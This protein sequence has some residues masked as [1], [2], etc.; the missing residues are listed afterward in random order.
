M[1]ELEFDLGQPGFKVCDP[2]HSGLLTLI[3]TYREIQYQNKAAETKIQT[4]R[5]KDRVMYMT[6]SCVHT[7]HKAACP[8][9]LSVL[10]GAWGS[11]VRKEAWNLLHA[12]LKYV[13]CSRG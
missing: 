3:H 4:Q 13:E 7:K 2:N 1:A 6:M 8:E 10:G 11:G 5:H 12:D 9:M